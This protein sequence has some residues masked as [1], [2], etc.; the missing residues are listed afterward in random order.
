MTWP[1]WPLTFSPRLTVQHAIFVL[2]LVL[3]AT[4][5]QAWEGVLVSVHDGDTVVVAPYGAP[6]GALLVRLYGI[7][8]PELDQVGGREAHAALQNLVQP[9]DAVSVVPL[10]GD[11]YSRV[12]GLVIHS[13]LILNYE[14]IRTGQAWVYPQYC[15]AR[16]CGEWRRVEESA[17]H[18]HAGLWQI[19]SPVPPWNWRKNTVR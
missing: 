17:R 18:S 3:L 16:F 14:Q 12:V 5:A 10:S 6:H 2:L 4:E 19:D 15:K 13:G 7:E 1:H 9:G 11:R 8:A